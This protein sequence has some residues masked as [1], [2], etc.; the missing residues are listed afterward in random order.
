MRKKSVASETVRV[1]IK[2]FPKATRAELD[3]LLARIDDPVDYSDDPP[4]DGPRQRVE[5]DVHGNLPE[6]LPALRKS[7]IRKAILEQLDRQQMTRYELWQK[8]RVHCPRIPGSAVYEYL[9]GQRE[10]GT[11]YVEAL[12]EAAG[13]TITPIGTRR[14][15]RAK[16]DRA[17]AAVASA[18]ARSPRG[19]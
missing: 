14:A 19:R 9:R 18:G 2:D 7:P 1:G 8:A 4:S 16:G 11:P 6:P 10:I 15:K 5:R 12:L 17:L 13:L 3:A